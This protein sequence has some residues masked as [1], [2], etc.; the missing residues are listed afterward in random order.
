M[1]I[2]SAGAW[3]FVALADEVAD[4]ETRMVDTM[5]LETIRDTYRP[6][7]LVE[8][9]RDITALGS[10][11]VLVMAVLA[12]A[13]FLL[14]SRRPKMMLYVVTS[15]VLGSLLV[16]VL[17][18]SFDRDRPVFAG[19]PATATASFPSGH[20]ALSAVV[21]VTLGGLLSQVTRRWRIKA[22]F[23]VAAL[24]LT[25]LVGFSRIYLS[26]HW[27]SDVLGGWSLGLAWATLSYA[28]LRVL[29]VRQWLEG[30]GY[31]LTDHGEEPLAETP[32]DEPE[33]RRLADMPA[34]S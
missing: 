33:N 16:Y 17:K 11:A 21:Y 15:V 9:F 32:L 30:P 6:V 8:T 20:A 10:N 18:G 26:V 13:V 25:L 23:I 2:V 3:G 14:I 7:W 31:R 29:Q 28:L 22:F 12:T 19:Q 5:L 34:G 1:V 27:P 24:L 4:N